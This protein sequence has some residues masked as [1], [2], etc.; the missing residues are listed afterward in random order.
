MNLVD[1]SLVPDLFPSP[2]TMHM[3]C[4]LLEFVQIALDLPVKITRSSLDLALIFLNEDR[5]VRRWILF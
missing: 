4:V 1:F 2:L 3:Y 5:D